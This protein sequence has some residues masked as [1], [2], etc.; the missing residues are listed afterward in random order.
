MRSVKRQKMQSVTSTQ[1]RCT[2]SKAFVW[3][4]PDHTSKDDAVA[5]ARAF[6]RDHAALSGYT[7]DAAQVVAEA[8]GDESDAFWDLFDAGM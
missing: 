8:D 1:C 6:L 2:P 4:H 3:H 7:G 5:A